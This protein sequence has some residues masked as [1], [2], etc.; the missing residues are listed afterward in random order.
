L[1]KSN[2]GETTL[3]E[4]NSAINRYIDLFNNMGEL[5]SDYKLAINGL[6][7]M[8]MYKTVCT[9]FEKQAFKYSDK[10]Q[11]SESET[12]KYNLSRTNL[13]FKFNV[14]AAL[15]IVMTLMFGKSMFTGGSSLFNFNFGN[16]AVSETIES[17]EANVNSN[18]LEPKGL[19]AFSLLLFFKQINKKNT[20]IY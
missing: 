16:Y 3:N 17:P 4:A 13:I 12:L 7:S 9:L 14:F 20:Y 8:Y 11:R 18:N 19:S 6:T 1:K 5:S 15:L 10:I 2:F